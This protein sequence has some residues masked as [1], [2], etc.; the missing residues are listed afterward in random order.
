MRPA[1]QGIGDVGGWSSYKQKDGMY[2]TP[3]GK[4]RFPANVIL[5]EEAGRMLNE[6]QEGASRF[7]YCAKA[8]NKERNKGCEDLITWENVDINPLMKNLNLH[9]KDISENMILSLENAEWS[10]SWCGKNILEKYHEDTKYI[11]LAEIK[12]IT[13]LKILKSST[14]L[15]T[16]ESIRD[17]I[18]EMTENSINLADAVEKLSL[19]LNNTVLKKGEESAIGAVNAALKTL[20]EIKEKGRK[21]NIHSTVKPIS[22][23]EYLV[24]LVTPP[25]GIVLDPF[26]GSGTTAL[27]CIKAN[28]NYI[29]VEKD[30]EY[31]KIACQRISDY[32]NPVEYRQS[33]LF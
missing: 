3:L 31:H 28:M 11:V 19:F 16:K 29:G 5:D 13:I 26:M 17:I 20:L 18:L 8:S 6:Q 23:I 33:E 2:G 4:G 9:L 24:T 32:L 12:L 27:A 14:L 21:G 30:D 1:R 25:G 22:L 7:F 15:H 10:I